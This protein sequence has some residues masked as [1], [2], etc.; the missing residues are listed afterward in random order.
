M[1]KVEEIA[2]LV[3]KGLKEKDLVILKADEEK[4]L[5]RMQEVILAD[6]KAEDDLDREV[7]GIL[8]AHAGEID[9]E[10]VDYRK[11]FRMLKNKLVKE[12]GIII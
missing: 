1:D 9:D 8:S 7:E 3:L 2:S 10:R 5:Q 12:R 4:V 11:M 6:L